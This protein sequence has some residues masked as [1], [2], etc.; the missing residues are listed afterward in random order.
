MTKKNVGYSTNEN[1]GLL[2]LSKSLIRVVISLTG[3]DV[4]ILA[5]HHHRH[6]LKSVESRV[7]SI[8]ILILMV[9]FLAFTSG[10]IVLSQ[11]FFKP[12]EP[13]WDAWGLI[14]SG[15]FS[16]S[17]LAHVIL[18]PLLLVC[19][20][21]IW[22]LVIL[23]IYRL[24]I[25][26]TISIDYKDRY[27]GI[28][29]LLFG[30]IFS[31]ICGFLLALPLIYLNFYED[32]NVY[33]KIDNIGLVRSSYQNIDEKH[34]DNLRSIYQDLFGELPRGIS[35]NEIGV[36]VDSSPVI[37]ANSNYQFLSTRSLDS[38]QGE[39]NCS[40]P[41]L[42]EKALNIKLVKRDIYNCVLELGDL[43]DQLQLQI[44]D[45]VNIQMTF[46]QRTLL[47]LKL[48][49]LKVQSD[50]LLS[51]YYHLD[52]PSIIQSSII[53]F[54]QF[55]VL[56]YVV[57]SFIIFMMLSPII[58]KLFETKSVYD[59]FVDEN[60]RLLIAHHGIELHTDDV[61]DHKSKD[62]GL[63]DRYYEFEEE[64][65]KVKR[66]FV[67]KLKNMD[68]V[69]LIKMQNKLFNIKKIINKD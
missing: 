15:S 35:P 31:I 10:G 60:N 30:F 34:H 14:F 63:I 57:I 33:K 27:R 19:I 21:L 69:E 52:P 50:K 22:A 23:N 13:Y 48:E 45:H 44:V 38:I 17:L 49:N 41:Y 62:F 6:A 55:G 1:S 20:G 56:T 68:T 65:L 26:I 40:A 36:Y 16:W 58:M 67:E 8:S 53:A 5:N 9:A 7:I 66:Q 47:S 4:M 32:I 18:L 25:I 12:D 39:K 43:A 51:L 28:F 29:R 42:D 37:P 59:Y 46:Y 2:G 11:L 3:F 61:V 64:Q 24:V 54:K